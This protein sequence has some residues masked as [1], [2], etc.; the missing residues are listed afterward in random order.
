M[1]AIHPFGFKKKKKNK[2]QN[3]IRLFV[4]LFE[5]ARGA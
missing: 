5:L 4:E 2:K 3:M 1:D